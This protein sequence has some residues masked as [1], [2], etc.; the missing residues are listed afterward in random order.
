MSECVGH[1]PCPSCGSRDNLGRYSDGHGYCFGCG[2]YEHAQGQQERK[3]RVSDST[4]LSNGEVRAIPSRALDEETCRK[5]GYKI[6][7]YRGDTVHI[8]E[9]RNADG[10]LIGQKIR[11][12]K[13]NFHIL[14]EGK[15]LPLYGQHL[16][17]S[18]G[19]RI[20]ITEGEIDA[21]SVAQACGLTWPVVSLPN[22]SS[23]ARKAIQRALDWLCGYET[24]VL[25]FDQDEPGRKAAAECAPLFP[26]GKCAIAELPRKDAN[27]MLVAGEVKAIASAMWNA[28]VYRPDGIVTL[29][30][31]EERVLAKPAQGRSYPFEGVTEATF[32]RRK[33]DVIGLGAGSGCGKTDFFTQMIAHDVMNLGV[34][35]GVIYLEQAV[36]ET[37]RRI[38]GKLAGRR[39]HVPDGSWT[40][41]ELRKAWDQ[42]KAT[43]RLQLYDSF[44]MMEWDQLKSKIRYLVTSLGCEHIYLDHLTALAA[45]EDDE[46]K[47]LERIMAEAAGMANELQFILHYVSHLATPD[48]KP[49]EEG[50][51]V[52][53]RHFKG[54]RAIMY[55]SHFLFGIE[56][57]TQE[58]G[59]PTILRCLKD[60]FTGQANGRTW[61]LHYDPRTGLLSECE[62]GPF[63]DE[64]VD[65]AEF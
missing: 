3:P 19:R 42:L 62:P 50:G 48:G 39:F 59:S 41:E 7:S 51:R 37:G 16:W 65:G 26:P 17:P 58:P 52:M 20:V 49:H 8:A 35:T 1:E 56:R 11:D 23:S 27:E 24:V 34:P 38:A 32:G 64:T 63:K 2:Y 4:F 60:R 15:E 10:T 21:L 18:S 43:K 44:G 54:A 57:D 22:G 36:A 13:K 28:R 61:G 45:A 9:F 40:E 55:W 12:K 47:A 5:F 14:G 46:R 25:C 31:I 6:G 29:D 33:G 30:E 53:G